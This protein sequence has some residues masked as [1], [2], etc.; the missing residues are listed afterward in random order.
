MQNQRSFID[1]DAGPAAL[2]KIRHIRVADL[3]DALTQ[4]LDDFWAMPSHAVFVALIYPVLGIFLTRLVLGY[5]VLPLLFPLIAGFALVG[6][7]A[8]TGMYELSRL[9]EQGAQPRW[10]D[11]FL[12][13]HSPSFRSILALGA[14]LMGIF[15]CWMYAAETIYLMTFGDMVPMSA[16]LFVHDVLTTPVGWELIIIGNGIGFLFAVAALLLSVVSF[17]LL[18]DRN[19]GAA[20]AMATSIRAVLANPVVMAV[21][22]LIVAVA[23]AVGAAFFLMGLAIVMPVLGHATWHL[24]RKVVER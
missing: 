14:L 10:K 20:A 12:V 2:P 1:L 6:P 17:P 5:D 23:L 3:K 13:L 4:G 7:F 19:I 24:Y 21:W 9:R 8:A 11:A 16:S 22:G 15:V 18:V